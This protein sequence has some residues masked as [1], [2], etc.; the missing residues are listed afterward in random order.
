MS[1]RASEPR[2]SS[3][4]CGGWTGASAG[5]REPAR[6]RRRP[7]RTLKQI[8]IRFAAPSV[9]VLGLGFSD[10]N[11]G[12]MDGDDFAVNRVGASGVLGSWLAS[13]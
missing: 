5:C 6:D 9:P 4:S 7:E 11:G 2:R 13:C 12:V 3:G 10:A 8:G 1:P